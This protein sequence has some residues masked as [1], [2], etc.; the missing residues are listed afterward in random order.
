[1]ALKTGGDEDPDVDL[2]LRVKAIPGEVGGIRHAVLAAAAACGMSDADLTDV[3]LATSE[4]CSNVVAHAYVDTAPG[5]MF[6]EASIIDGEFVVVVS[7]EGEG[8]APRADSPGLGIGLALIARLTH[9]MEIG[10][11]GLGGAKLTMAFSLAG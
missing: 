3:G 9:R 10:S 4:A 5:L 6:V 2:R 11:N 1:M 8:V 7:D